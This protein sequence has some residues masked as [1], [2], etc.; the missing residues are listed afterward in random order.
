MS[1]TIPRHFISGSVWPSLMLVV[2]LCML[3][4]FCRLL[5]VRIIRSWQRASTNGSL[6]ELLHIMAYGV[7]V[8]QQQQE[9]QFIRRKRC[10][11]LA[12]VEPQSARGRSGSGC[13]W[14]V[15]Q[16]RLGAPGQG[17]LSA[18][19]GRRGIMHACLGV[20]ASAGDLTCKNMVNGCDTRC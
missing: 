12:Q 14:W 3:L 15:P 19:P 2:T 11:C 8:Q 4:L 20:M 17:C 1:Q 13:C 16:G 18:A 10:T 5:Y 9:W 6:S 7:T